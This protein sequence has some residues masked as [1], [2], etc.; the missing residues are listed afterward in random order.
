MDAQHIIAPVDDDAEI[1]RFTVAQVAR[2]GTVL[3][4]TEPFELAG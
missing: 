3:G 2:D 4:A 1:E